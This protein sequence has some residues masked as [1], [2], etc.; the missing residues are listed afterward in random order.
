MP[1]IVTM[2]AQTLHLNAELLDPLRP[3]RGQYFAILDSSPQLQSAAVRWYGFRL[4]AEERVEP[5]RADWDARYRSYWEEGAMRHR[6]C[7]VIAVLVVRSMLMAIALNATLPSSIYAVRALSISS[8]GS[9]PTVPVT[10]SPPSRSLSPSPSTEGSTAAYPPNLQPSPTLPHGPALLEAASHISSRGAGSAQQPPDA[11]DAQGIDVASYQHDDGPVDW[12]TV[13]QNFQFAY[14]KATEGNYY[15]NPYYRTDVLDAL[16]NGMYVGAY[17]FAVPE[18]D[19]TSGQAEADYFLDATGY[20]VGPHFMVPMVDLESDPYDASTPCYGLTTQ[21]MIMWLQEFSEEIQNKI[22]EVPVIYTDASWWNMCTGGTSQFS[23]SPLWIASF[24]TQSPT[25]PSGFTSWEIWQY[26]VGSAPGVIGPCDLDEFDGDVASLAAKL[27]SETGGELIRSGPVDVASSG[28]RF[29]VFFRGTDGA[30]WDRVSVNGMV[31]T[32]SLGGQVEP[33]TSP[34][35]VSWGGGRLDVF[36]EGTDQQLYQDFWNGATWSGWLPLG[37]TLTSSP[38]VAS[39][40]VGRLD[41][42][43]A[44]S[45]GAIWHRWYMGGW[46]SWESLGGEVATGTGPSAVS[47]GAGRLDLFVTGV[48]HQLWHK[49]FS[50]G[51][52][53]AY[54]ALGGTLTSSP[55]AASWGSGRLDVFASGPDYELDHI[56]FSSGWA[57]WESLGGIL[58]SAPAATSLGAGNVEVVVRGT[59]SSIYLDTFSLSSSWSGFTSLGETVG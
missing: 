4:T 5:E 37:G 13:A 45:D 40:A 56:W 8:D 6:R 24:G 14:V 23:S 36:V 25:L 10:S 28:G 1:T 18:P 48:D 21:Q 54:E 32:V 49:W 3:D 51:V 2:F 7:P 35:A 22:G 42:F 59:D 34:A 26:G 55:G 41:V 19:V 12:A 39:W 20:S 16:A 9:A 15:T 44:G 30:V 57:G 52:W 17:T 38:T 31:T 53:S 43:V 46:S 58:A 29:D 11:G 50:S 27:T 47:W 33:N